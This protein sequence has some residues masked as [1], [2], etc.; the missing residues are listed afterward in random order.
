MMRNLG[1]YCVPL[2]LASL[3]ASGCV[4]V[5]STAWG[6]DGGQHGSRVWTDEVT[7]RL[8]IDTQGASGLTAKTHNGSIVFEGGSAD[9][10]EAFVVVKKKA[11]GRT[12]DDAAEAFAAID[13]FVKRAKDGRQRIGW[14]WLGEKKRRWTAQVSF[15]IHAPG[16]LDFEAETH[17]GAIRV[18]GA[19]GDVAVATHNGPVVVEAGTGKLSAETHNGG[20][21]ATYSGEDLT[22]TT[23]NGSVTAKL[24]RCQKLS[25]RV[26][27][28][29]GR[30]ELAVG[31][32]TSTKLDCRTAN[33]RIRCKAPV[34]LSESR[35]GRLIGTLGD[36][37]GN[38]KVTTHNGGLVITRT[39]G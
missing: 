31:E 8:T 1:L 32:A 7:E 13:V 24:G 34:V 11:G 19:R 21:D 36:G 38:L 4:V 15:E 39:T 37:D 5:C 6:S 16:E 22:L 2:A 27:T 26:T 3:L 35:R 18:K 9:A 33:G 25:G 29:N 12:A 28:H 17:N 14:K 10:G 23:H 20:I 30:I